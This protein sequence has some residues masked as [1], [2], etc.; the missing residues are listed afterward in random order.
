MRKVEG[1]DGS[2]VKLIKSLVLR[3]MSD[4]RYNVLHDDEC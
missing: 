1:I 2:V 3:K 4:F